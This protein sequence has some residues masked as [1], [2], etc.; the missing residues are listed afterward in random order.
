MKKENLPKWQLTLAIVALLLGIYGIF[1]GSNFSFSYGDVVKP[2]IEFTTNTIAILI[3]SV[4][5]LISRKK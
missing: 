3:L 2:Q 5:A 1:G 4:F